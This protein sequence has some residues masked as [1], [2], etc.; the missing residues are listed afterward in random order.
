MLSTAVKKPR[1]EKLLR[2]GMYDL[3]RTLGKGNFAIVKLGVHKLTR[4]KV[5]VKIVNKDDLDDENLSKIYREIEIM[6]KLSHK[7]IIQLYQ[8]MES[9]TFMY[10]ITEFAANG[11]IFDWLVTN[12]KMSESQAAKTFSQILAAVNYC[13]QHGVVH[14]DLKAENLLLD[15]DGNI[16]LADFGFSNYYKAGDS[17]STWCGS[18]PYAAPELFEGRQYDGPKADIWSL[19]VILYVLVSGSLPFDGQTLQDLRSRIVS[20]QYRIPFFLS[21]DCEHLIRGLLVVDPVK[22]L[23]LSFIARHRWLVSQL[24]TAAHQTLLDDMSSE[25]GETVVQYSDIVM[26]RVVMLSGCDITVDT[27]LESLVQNKCDDLSAIYHLLE[28]NSAIL[29][30]CGGGGQVSLAG[31]SVTEVYTDTESSSEHSRPG[32]QPHSG[33]RRH[34]LGPANNAIPASVLQVLQSPPPADHLQKHL[35]PHINLTQ[36]LP[37]VSNQPFTDFSVKAPDQLRAPPM[38]VMGRRASDCGVY[39]SLTPADDGVSLLNEDSD[40]RNSDETSLELTIYDHETGAAV[41]SSGAGMHYLSRGAAAER[42]PSQGSYSPDSP[43]KRRTGL[44]TVMEKPPDITDEVIS[45]VEARIQ[46]QHQRSISPGPGYLHF[47]HQHHDSPSSLSPMSPVSVVSSPSHFS[48]LGTNRRGRNSCSRVSSLKEP[49]SIHLS[50]ERYSPV[51]RLSEGAPLLRS[52]LLSSCDQSPCEISSLQEE[53]RQLNQ[54]TRLSIDS[55]SS[56]YHSP[57]YLCPPTPPVSLSPG[58]QHSSVRRRSESNVGQLEHTAPHNTHDTRHSDLMAAMY[59]D[60]YSTRDHSSSRRS[61]YPNSPAHT[62]IGSKEKQILSQQLQ[63]LCL[64]NTRISEVQAE[65]SLGVRFKGSITQG[66]PSLAATTPTTPGITPATTPKHNI[67]HVTDKTATQ[68]FD[69]T[70]SQQISYTLF[71]SNYAPAS[72]TFFHLS[73]TS[74]QPSAGQNPEISVTNE[75]GDEIKFVLTEPM[76]ESH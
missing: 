22:R 21:R 14:R 6:R 43:R 62:S 74:V 61:S 57:Q 3:E 32:S 64:Q 69:E 68:S 59:E 29:D 41:P 28:Y 26:E 19:G 50:N 49:H 48:G 9:D 52:S 11:E 34:T 4:T 40:S 24:D 70:F 33:Q 46:Q 2:V 25:Q 23:S 20:C 45:D 30:T 5:A 27:V 56:G 39:S 37:L 47:P 13:H 31:D 53:Y 18:P 60:M 72:N 51:R 12:K 15:H 58:Q 71:G 8:V 7:N 16:K 10:I 55:T 35:L 36:N 73:E 42:R 66:V 54:E 76:D 67:K 38:V 1:A 75:R 65:P 63:R 44:M 17:L